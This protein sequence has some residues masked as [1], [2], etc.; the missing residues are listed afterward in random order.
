MES[1]QPPPDDCVYNVRDPGCDGF[2]PGESG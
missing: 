2:A 1:I